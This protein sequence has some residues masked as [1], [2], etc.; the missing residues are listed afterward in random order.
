MRRFLQGFLVSGALTLFAAC[1]PTVS[2]DVDINTE[3]VVESGTLVEGLLEQMR[4]GDLVSMDVSSTEE[5]QNNQAEKER[6]I[7]ARLR[8][9]RLLIAAPKGQTFDF[10]D[11]IAFF[12]G[13]P[14]QPRERVAHKVVPDGIDAFDLELDDVD[15]APYVRAESL[16]LTTDV[17]GRRPAQDTTVAVRLVLHIVAAVGP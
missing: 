17:T 2:F 7:E 16:S 6:V 8:E 15:L 9:A 5:F 3:T 10:I 1:A 14:G 11:E 13:A 12:V 4:F